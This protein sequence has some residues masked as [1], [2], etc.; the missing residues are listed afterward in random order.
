MKAKLSICAVA[1]LSVLALPEAANAGKMSSV[2]GGDILKRKGCNGLVNVN[3]PELK[4]GARKAEVDK[5]LA[6][7]DAYSK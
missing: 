6:D 7:P 1:L 5:C 3:H 4:G 2:N